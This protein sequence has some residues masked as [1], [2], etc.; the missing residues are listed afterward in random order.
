MVFVCVS[1]MTDHYTMSEEEEEV[2][3]LY[4]LYGIIIRTSR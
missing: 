3:C 2:R 1:E 4:D